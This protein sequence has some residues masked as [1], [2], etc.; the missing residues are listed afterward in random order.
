[1]IDAHTL[2]AVSQRIGDLLPPLPLASRMEL[3]SSL[4]HALQLGLAPLNPVTRVEFEALRLLLRY[5]REHLDSFGPRLAELERA[6]SEQALGVSAVPLRAL[7]AQSYGAVTAAGL[8][9]CRN[10]V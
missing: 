4:R 6:Q 2:N 9:S 1:M 3:Q 5:V 8:D 7:H 10:S